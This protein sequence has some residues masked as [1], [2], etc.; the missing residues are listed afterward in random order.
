MSKKTKRPVAVNTPG[1]PQSVAP[2]AGKSHRS[3]RLLLGGLGLLLVAVAVYYFVAKPGES[4]G[5]NLSADSGAEPTL[6]AKNPRLQLLSP[7]ETG[8]H[9]QNFIQ[10][11][12]AHNII[13]NLNQYI[14]GGIAVADVNND[15]QPDLYFVS[16]SG[17]NCLYLNE[18]QGSGGIKF[19]DI[20][21]AAGVGN[22]EGFKTSVT[23]ADVNAD[24][25]IDLF[26]CHAGPDLAG[27]AAKLFINNGLSPN[28]SPACGRRGPV[29]RQRGCF[30][31]C[32]N[33]I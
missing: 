12:S 27:R 25:W 11:D 24:G 2:V 19:R 1:R 26:V 33:R 5:P 28:P 8:V 9:F 14:G 4:K 21:D 29:G 3:R 18:S 16:S 32:V 31:A 6:T 22:Q 10:E 20:T 23:A 30:H 7:Q 13:L 15:N 17:K